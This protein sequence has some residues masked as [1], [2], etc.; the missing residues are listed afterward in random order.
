MK[1]AVTGASGHI[2][3]CLVRELKKQGAEVK[4]LVHDFKND[5]DKLD[6]EIIQGNLLDP[7]SLNL[8]CSGAHVVFHLAAII[9]LDNRHSENVYAVN[10]TGTKNMIAAS[11]SAGVKKFIHFSS[12]D[13]FA[14]V[15][16]DQVL[17]EECPL[18]ETRDSIYEITKAESERLVMKAV[19]EGLDAII[20]CPT[21]VVGPFD[22]RGSFLG[23][24]LKK[25]FM[26]KL[27]MLVKG[28]Y[29]WV[30]VRDVADA[31]IRSVEKGR[32]G[33][34]YILSG[35]YADLT[36]L[37]ATAGKITGKK[38]PSMTAP[39]FLAKLAL[40]FLGVYYSMFNGKPIY[41]SQSLN[42]LINSPKN[43]SFEK[44]KKE[45]GYIPRPLEQT[46]SDTF[47]WYQENKF[48]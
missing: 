12:I 11:M 28:G 30:D 19:T 5:L 25:I 32:K 3:N 6:V 8:L 35:N 7:E 36:V 9:A 26:N 31:A 21:A 45:L 24:A 13:A 4:V 10:V 20:L 43:I 47:I 1:V 29:N 17:D 33:E 38:T 48:I 41:T 34:K 16:T 18:I 40:P 2:G 42:L 44:A 22:Y 27:P 23:D 14:K 37:S 39:V 46:L 15:R